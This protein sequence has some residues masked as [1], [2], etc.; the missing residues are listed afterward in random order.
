[1]L[2]LRT[3]MITTAFVWVAMSGCAF[4][5]EVAGEEADLAEPFESTEEVDVDSQELI[6]ADDPDAEQLEAIDVGDLAEQARRGDG[7]AD[8]HWCGN[9][10]RCCV[11]GPEGQV[12]YP[13]SC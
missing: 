5:H 10:Y 8:C 12:C 4:D 7:D 3:V 1:M 9:V 11:I 2:Q 13:A 6:T